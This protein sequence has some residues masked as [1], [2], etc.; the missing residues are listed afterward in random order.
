MDIE[1]KPF[2]EEIGYSANADEKGFHPSGVPNNPYIFKMKDITIWYVSPNRTS[3]SLPKEAQYGDWMAANLANGY[4][5]NHRSYAGL[6]AALMGELLQAPI[7]SEYL[8]L[9]LNDSD[10]V[11]KVAERKN[12]TLDARE[13]RE[14]TEFA[15]SHFKL[16]CWLFYYSR[17]V[18]LTDGFNDR[19]DCARRIFQAGFTNP[20]SRFF[21][22]FDFGERN[23]DTIFEMNDGDQVVE[24]L[25]R[26]IHGDKTGNIAKAFAEHGW[27][28]SSEA[29]AA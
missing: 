28:I 4:F 23:F 5:I 21:T 2:A 22:V 26:L 18:G 11:R 14:E 7:K 27:S 3:V 12:T 6:H 29:L 17:R 9:L 20:R 25:R 1:L 24:A 15:K 8:D 13:E 19:V 10:N 16:G